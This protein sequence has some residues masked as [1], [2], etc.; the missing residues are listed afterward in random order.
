MKTAALLIALFVAG[1]YQVSIPYFSRARN[2]AMQ[3]TAQNYFV[4]DPDIWK[5][6]RPDL[7]DLRLYDG[8]A[9]VPYALVEQSGGSSSQESPA[10]ILNL[11]KVEITLNSIL[12]FAV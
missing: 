4:V 12:M 10:G 2:V 11:G 5:F 1:G 3:S 8:Q 7:S 9:Q 6:A